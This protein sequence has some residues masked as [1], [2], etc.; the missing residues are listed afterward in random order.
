V[1]APANKFVGSGREIWFGKHVG[2]PKVT[3]VKVVKLT[4]LIFVTL[5]GLH[6]DRREYTPPTV[7]KVE[8]VIWWVLLLVGGESEGVSSRF[9]ERGRGSQ[10]RR[11]G[12]QLPACRFRA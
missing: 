7:Q 12:L 6:G 5:G 2:P 8:G 11:G 10:R 9:W 4:F 1:L 3:E